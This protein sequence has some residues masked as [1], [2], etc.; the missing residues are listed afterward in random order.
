VIGIIVAGPGPT[1]DDFI[2]N[3]YLDY[4]LQRSVLAVLDTS[5]AGGEGVREALDKAQDVIQ[6]YRLIEEKRLVRK[7][8]DEI[9]PMELAS[10]DLSNAL[11]ELLHSNKDVIAVVHKRIKHKVAD[12]YK[13]KADKVIEV[14]KGN[15]DTLLKYTVDYYLR[16]GKQER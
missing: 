14:T 4:R 9:V 8:F 5:Y 11:M 2:K 7:L 15:R 12:M 16:E 3:C 10:D 1:K 13:A 6:E